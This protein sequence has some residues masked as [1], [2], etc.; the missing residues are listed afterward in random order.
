MNACLRCIITCVN[1]LVFLSSLCVVYYGRVR[2]MLKGSFNE[3]VVNEMADRVKGLLSEEIINYNLVMFGIIVALFSIGFMIYF[4]L[5]TSMETRIEKTIQTNVDRLVQ[6]L[7]TAEVNEQN[8]ERNEENRQNALDRLV[9][10]LERAEENEQR[11]VHVLER[12][13]ANQNRQIAFERFHVQLSPI[14]IMFP[15]T[16][17]D[18]RLANARFLFD[19]GN[20]LSYC[21]KNSINEGLQITPPNTPNFPFV[22]CSLFH[23]QVFQLEK[24]MF[25]WGR[26]NNNGS[27]HKIDG[28]SFVGE[29]HF[30]HRNTRFPNLAEA[31]RHPEE[32]GTLFFAVFLQLDVNDNQLLGPLVDVLSRLKYAGSECHISEHFK[33]SQ[34]FPENKNEFWLYEGSEVVEPFR[35]KVNWLIFRSTLQISLNQLTKLREL[36]RTSQDNALDQPLLSNRPLQPIN[37]R[38]IKSSFRWQ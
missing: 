18:Q 27:L 13:E 38:L 36:R 14:N 23:G 19:Y 7:E 3:N 8:R 22:N 26:G 30:Q 16:A 17:F 9:R 24:I 5:F 32:H 35:E 2:A 11:L 15:S 21:A 33:P 1:L 25:H 31:L 34:L 29:V 4:F 10:V 28:I 20:N 6:F 12:A 37:D